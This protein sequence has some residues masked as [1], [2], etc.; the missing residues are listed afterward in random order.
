[1]KKYLFLSMIIGVIAASAL[2]TIGYK[3]GKEQ[4]KDFTP[5][6]GYKE[7]IVGMKR[8]KLNTK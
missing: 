6:Q 4:M 2:F 5:K 8:A 7:R 3:L 1:M